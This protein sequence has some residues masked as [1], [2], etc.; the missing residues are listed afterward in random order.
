M[1][2]ATHEKANELYE[3]IVKTEVKLEGLEKQASSLRF[4]NNGINVCVIPD[5]DEIFTTIKEL[6]SALLRKRLAEL[7]IEYRKL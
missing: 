6:A 1:T 3:K 5:N 4:S 2:E 7:K